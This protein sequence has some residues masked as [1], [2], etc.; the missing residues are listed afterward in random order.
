MIQKYSLKNG[1][2]RYMFHS[3]IGVDPVTNKEVYRKRRGFKTKKQAE[4]AEARLIN[5]FNEH[6]FPSERKRSTF[7]E[8]YE[9]WLESEYEDNVQESTLNKTTRDFRNH[10]IPSFDGM[11][12]REI[13]PDHCQSEL[14]KWRDKLVNYRRIKNYANRVFDYALRMDIID[15]NPFDKVTVPKRIETIDDSE[16]EN[17]YTKEELNE[18]LDYVKEDLDFNWYVYFRILAYSGARKS[19]ILALK[20]SDIDFDTSTLNINKTLTR[21]LNN[22]IIVQPT[23]TVNGRRVIDMD[24]DSMKLL[25]QWKMYQAQFMLKLGF[26]TNTPDQLV[27]ANTRNNFYSINVPNDR[28]RN[29]Q[30]RNGLKQITVHG[31]RHTHCSILFSMGASIK[32]VQ[33]RLGHTDIQTT[34]NIY[35]HVTKEEKKDTAD[36]FA[37]FMEN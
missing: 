20:W 24:Y 30:K 4:I 35:A 13:K 14:N 27:F 19:E 9:L 22:K 37:K 1:E 3:Y 26:N 11:N 21:G 12:I 7:N 8:V 31:L 2:T 16:F 32:D 23:K 15:S 6:G 25:K 33:A 18:F 29:V 5:E 34:M 17:F 36:K 10:I 28:M